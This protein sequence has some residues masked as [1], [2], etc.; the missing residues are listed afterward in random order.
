MRETGLHIAIIPKLM[1]GSELGD[2]IALHEEFRGHQS[3]KSPKFALW[4]SYNDMVESLL[5]FVRNTRESNWDLH[6]VGVRSMQPCIFT[7]DTN[8]YCRYLSVY[9]TDN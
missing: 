1:L 3:D 7:Y 4:S 2:V 6:I 8:N 9:W 5:W